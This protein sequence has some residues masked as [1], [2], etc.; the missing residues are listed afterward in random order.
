M[1][2]VE[3]AKPDMSLFSDMAGTRVVL[4]RMTGQT[5]T[6]TFETALV[7]FEG[8]EAPTPF[9]G[10]GAGRAYNLM[11]R[12]SGKEHAQMAALLNL[13]RQAHDAV[14]GRIALRTNA[15]QV[16]DL[17]PFEVVSVDSIS[18]T[19]IGGLA[20]EVSWVATAVQFSIE[21]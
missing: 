7:R 5:R 10:G 17:Q 21:V 14:D 9:R 11:V 13:F 8:D 12:Y 16:A 1:A 18:E 4:P 6:R 20:W 2:S 3:L 19:P 15:Y